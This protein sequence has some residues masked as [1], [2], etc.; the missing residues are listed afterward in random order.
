MSDKSLYSFR[1]LSKEK[2]LMEFQKPETEDYVAP[3]L[4]DD[5]L[6]GNVETGAE[7]HGEISE[8]MPPKLLSFT[9]TREYILK[10]FYFF[11]TSSGKEKRATRSPSKGYMKP[12]IDKL[13]ALDS[14]LEGDIPK[15]AEGALDEKAL[16]KATT[17]FLDT[18]EACDKYLDKRKNPWTDEGKAR[19]AMVNDLRQ[20]VATESLLF[21]ERIKE[22]KEKPDTIPADG[23]W[24]SVLTDIR[25]EK[26]EDGKDG[27]IVSSD[28]GGTSDLIVIEKNG[29]RQ[30]IKQNEK[31]P[32]ADP[33]IYFQSEID[34]IDAEYE[35]ADEE[36]KAYLDNCKK[37]I[38]GVKRD[39]RTFYDNKYSEPV[40]QLYV[41]FY[42]NQRE[43]TLEKVNDYL[44]KIFS[45][46]KDSQAPLKVKYEKQKEEAEKYEIELRHMREKKKGNT[47][48][49]KELE[50]KHKRLLGQMEQS[51]YLFLAR[52]FS[53]MLK[54]RVMRSLAIKSAKIGEGA[55]ITKRNVATKRVA[56]ALGLSDLVVDTKLAE[57]QVG[58]KKINGI[59]M[60]NA[61]GV[62]QRELYYKAEDEGKK[63]S[64]SPQAYKQIMEL[65][66]LDIICGQVDRNVSNFLCDYK[67]DEKGNY[68]IEKVTAIDNDLSF[69]N[70]NYDQLLHHV[71]TMET[72]V[73]SIEDK[74]GHMQMPAIDNKLAQFIV[75][76]KPEE[77]EYRMLD[78][79]DKKERKALVSRLKGVQ[80]V[81]RSQMQREDNDRVGN[82]TFQSKFP[83]NDEEWKESLKRLERNVKN[84]SRAR[85]ALL[86]VVNNRFASEKE[87][88]M[89]SRALD[90]TPDIEK[91]SYLMT[92]IMGGEY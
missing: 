59:V 40:E 92:G 52:T 51:D 57:V 54:D 22:L 84:D 49:Y 6:M 89:A 25:T 26:Y 13:A 90:K 56:E 15:T 36:K 76:M 74:F 29:V 4:F 9:N 31:V 91:M 19:Y 60:D 42:K 18:L 68:I 41:N 78:I 10:G 39:M 70:M 80:R 2:D 73:R 33:G 38:E 30:Y 5:N 55:D 88:E 46:I 66:V 12:V 81:I 48:E 7:I 69:G 34:R 72:P 86:D 87:R 62:S 37:Q 16:D 77:L 35:G 50:E 85:N 17:Y 63:V 27:V 8:N 47:P 53:K 24:I 32:P 67:K 82:N 44:N 3:A 83:K 71:Y 14:F 11:K 64:Y 61:K 58:D 23:K 45:H 20:K 65:Q 79:L 21:S 75:N 1:D 28:G 43:M